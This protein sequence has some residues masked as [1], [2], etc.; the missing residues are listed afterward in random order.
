[1][2]NLLDEKLPNHRGAHY[3]HSGLHAACSLES[4]VTQQWLVRVFLLV[5]RIN[6]LY[7]G[8]CY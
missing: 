4:T 1:M 7:Q 2:I 8:W 3:R 5:H 6:I